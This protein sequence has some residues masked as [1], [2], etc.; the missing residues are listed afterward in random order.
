MSACHA[1]RIGHGDSRWFAALGHLHLKGCRDDGPVERRTIA[2]STASIRMPVRYRGRSHGERPAAV[3]HRRM[4]RPRLREFGRLKR[5]RTLEIAIRI[6]GHR[7]DP[8]L[9]P[10][11][12]CTRARVGLPGLRAR[13]RRGYRGSANGYRPGQRAVDLSPDFPGSRI[14]LRVATWRH[15]SS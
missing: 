9:F 3:L 10:S 6:R 5:S 11:G 14:R 8:C 12:P 15:L 4:E 1:W 7:F 2:S 13:Y